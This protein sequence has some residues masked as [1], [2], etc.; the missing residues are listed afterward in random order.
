MSAFVL[1]CPVCGATRPSS[2]E[3]RGDCPH[4]GEHHL[5]LVERDRLHEYRGRIDEPVIEEP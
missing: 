2:R 5:V 1:A 3:H 4:C